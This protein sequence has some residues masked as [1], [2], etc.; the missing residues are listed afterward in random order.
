MF[1][2]QSIH[3]LLQQKKVRLILAAICVF[4]AI[5]GGYL[6]LNGD[7]QQDWLRGGGNL[8]IWGGFAVSNLM[9]AYGRTQAG[10]NIPINIGGLLIVASWIIQS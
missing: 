2:G 6:L 4:F 3:E 5:T 1:S 9:K 8:L 7:R 10:L